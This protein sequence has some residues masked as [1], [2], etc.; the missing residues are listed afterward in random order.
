VT[1]LLDGETLRTRVER[2]R[3][4]T[5]IAQRI[6]AEIADGLMAAHAAQLVHRDLKPE[7]IFLTRGGPTKILDFGIAKLAQDT[8]GR[9]RLSTL[10][11]VLLGTAGYLAPEQVI[12]DAVDS[13]ADLFA[14]GS[15]LFEM[16]SGRRAFARENTVDTL[17]AIV[18]D[19]PPN[20]L[21]EAA[22]VPPALVAIVMRLLEKAPGD[23]FQTSADLAWALAHS[24]RES[25][26][27]LPRPPSGSRPAAQRRLRRPLW[28][29]VAT[30]LAAVGYV[31]WR[32][33]RPRPA[34]DPWLTRFTSALPTGVSLSSAP[35]ISPDG[36]TLIFAGL[37]GSESRLFTRRLDSLET[38]AIAGTDGAKQ[39]F[40]SPDGA[41]VGFFAHG[42][43]LKIVVAGG[44]PVEI[45][46]APDGR[47]GAWSRSDE[48]VFAPDLTEA[49]ISRVSAGGGR[50]EAVTR[51]DVAQG[52][53][54]HR[55]PIFLPDGIHFLYFVRSTDDARRGVYV[56]RSDQPPAIPGTLLIR[57]ESGAV[58]APPRAPDDPGI[59][60]YVMNGQIEAQRFDAARLALVGNARMVG[61]AAG[62]NTLYEAAMVSA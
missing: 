21:I 48:M 37:D 58:F 32:D 46:D 52:E 17:H 30:V 1:E 5:E 16:L 19:A 29:A 35:A 50:V 38:T 15:I 60:L 10:T 18:H 13:R 42:K 23:R 22:S 40:W 51:L 12:G 2:G 56:G 33:T 28:I 6:A 3:L 44:A 25:A 47:G 62:G 39:P 43:L 45:A 34:E 61:V 7:N 31:G 8:V 59:L 20:L 24:G 36:R 54:S 41:S 55:W 4:P 9:A 53:N 11:G 49:A 27:A 57:S 14:L 26:D